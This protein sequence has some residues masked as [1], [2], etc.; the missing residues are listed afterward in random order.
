MQSFIRSVHTCSYFYF[1]FQPLTTRLEI[2]EF[3]PWFKMRKK[4]KKKWFPGP[5]RNSLTEMEQ[6]QPRVWMTAVCLRG[7]KTPYGVERSLG[8]EPKEY[9]GRKIPTGQWGRYS[10]GKSSPLRDKDGVK[11]VALAEKHFKGSAPWFHHPFWS[12]AQDTSKNHDIYSVLQCGNPKIIE[13]LLE[14]EPIW[15]LL[16][17]SIRPITKEI[18][19]RLIKIGGLDGLY[20]AILLIHHSHQIISSKLYMMAIKILHGI[21]PTLVTIPELKPVHAKL[22]DQL[23]LHYPGWIFAAPNIQYRDNHTWRYRRE[24]YW[25]AR[26]RKLSIEAEPESYRY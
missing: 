16:Y 6:L 14:E 19:N 13:L 7:G 17:T 23:D 4:L 11:R 2:G 26:L 1:T 22:L 10:R 9:D 8:K 24:K 21:E 25:P 20:A 15:D 5:G 12:I 3:L 18:C